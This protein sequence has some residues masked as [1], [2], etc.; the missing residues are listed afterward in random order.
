MLKLPPNTTVQVEEKE[1]SLTQIVDSSKIFMTLKFAD[2]TK[3]LIDSSD[4]DIITLNELHSFFQK[5]L[6]QNNLL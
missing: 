4:A 6:I 3:I 5:F 1:A 2:K